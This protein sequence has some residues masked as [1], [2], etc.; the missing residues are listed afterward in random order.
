MIKNEEEEDVEITSEE[1]VLDTEEET[2]QED[3]SQN[4]E[5]WKKKAEEFQGRLK[6]AETKLDKSKEK[7]A[8]KVEE[9]SNVL[10]SLD[11][12]ALAK[13]DVEDE[14]L[15]DIEEY[16][17]LKKISV[18]EALKS[19]FVKNLLADKKEFKQ[20]KEIAN[21]GTKRSTTANVTDE[22]FLAKARSGKELSTEELQR[23]A[24]I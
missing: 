19:T 10:S 9:T 11:L 13:A 3:E 5:Y 21:T 24:S 23:L 12:L 18:R 15:P 2:E 1:E 22:Q 17:K 16:A 20:S 8:E 4:A 6:R 7:P 14:D